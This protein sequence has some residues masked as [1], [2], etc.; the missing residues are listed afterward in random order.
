MSDND[1]VLRIPH[2]LG[3]PEAKKRIANG[4]AAAKA[5]YGNYFTTSQTEWHEN[6]LAFRLTALAQTI[7]G[8]VDV[9]DDYVELKAQLP[10]MI[11]LL[12]KRFVPLVQD[13]GQKLLTKKP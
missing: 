6:R 8:T 12:A 1:L 5:Q 9:E 7:R 4:V 11:R 10:M 13:T 2:S 3:A